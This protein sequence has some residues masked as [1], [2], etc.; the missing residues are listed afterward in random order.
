MHPKVTIAYVFNESLSATIPCLQRL[1]DKT[2][3]GTYTLIC[4]DGN[5]PGSI[6]IPLQQLSS[7]HDF[8]L[9]RSNEYLTQ[10]E[11]RNIALKQVQTQYVVFVDNDVEVGENWL[12]HLVNCADETGAWLVAPLYMESINGQLAVHMYGGECDFKDS[13]GTPR[14][15]EKHLGQHVQLETIKPL[16]RHQTNLVEFHTLLMNMD[17]YHAL[18]ELDEK[19]L[20]HSQHTDL[21]YAVNKAE[22]KIFIEPLSVITHLRPEGRLEE[23]DKEYYSLR[24]NEA[25]SNKTLEH[26]YDKY[27]IPIDESGM[28]MLSWWVRFHRQEIIA[29]YPIIRKI[30][31]SRL[32]NLYRTHIGLHIERRL[33]ML[34][35]PVT[36]YAQKRT[37]NIEK[38]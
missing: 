14:Y 27:L 24:W 3:P 7:K 26:L 15:I 12:D 21:C 32:H 23:I 10:N 4:V 8:T 20:N 29:D 34:K 5:S 38:Q 19:L 22:Q 17:A 13:Y 6:S 36:K 1:I 37:V 16:I 11:S 18:G 28:K 31:R 25:W 2:S 9:I 33:N 35:Y 30:F